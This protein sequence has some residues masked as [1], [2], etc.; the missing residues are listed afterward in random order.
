M[1]RTG[2]PAARLSSCTR[3]PRR[4]GGTAMALSDFE[5]RRLEELEQG[6]LHDAPD[7]AHVLESRWSS[8]RRSARRV[9][10][11][12]A[13]IGGFALVVVGIAAQLAIVGIIGFLL[14]IAGTTSYFATHPGPRGHPQGP[15][16]PPNDKR[17][18]T[19]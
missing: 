4:A 15:G 8:H 11:V 10:G 17:W 14:M 2:L 5:R 6:L 13:L 18:P 1:K 12:L 3:R 7:L 16:K 9:L 19:Q